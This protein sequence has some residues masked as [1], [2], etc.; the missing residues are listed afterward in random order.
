[1]LV[2]FIE[3]SLTV[4]NFMPFITLQAYQNPTK[5]K[6]TIKWYMATLKEI[7]LF[8]GDIIVV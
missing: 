6:V 7:T 1:M 4:T 5:S 3:S 2:T 8:L